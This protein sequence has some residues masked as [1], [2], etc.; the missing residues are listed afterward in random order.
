MLRSAAVTGERAHYICAACEH[1]S[2]I[3]P[4]VLGASDQWV[5][6]FANYSG[7]DNANNVGVI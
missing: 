7:W 4:V 5:S 1:G 6:S 2:V 3:S